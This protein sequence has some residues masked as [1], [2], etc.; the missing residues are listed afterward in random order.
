MR[1]N[2]ENS[3]NSKAKFR[4]GIR[5]RIALWFILGATALLTLGGY[6]V[7]VTGLS[8]IQGTLGQTYCQIAG[9]VSDQFQV[10]L[11][12]RYTLIRGIAT[13]VLTAAVLV[14]AADSYAKRDDAW[15]DAR[16]ARLQKEWLQ[17]TI[18]EKSA[19]LHPQ[20]S[21]RLSV[22]A[23]LERT[24]PHALNVYDNKGVLVAALNQ[25]E[26]RV[27]RGTDIY[28]NI[29][30][31]K[32]HFNYV[33]FNREPDTITVIL[34]VWSGT[35]IAGYVMGE[36]DFTVIM[37]GIGDTE[38]GRSGEAV[39]V[40][41]AGVPLMGTAQKYLFDAMKQTSTR[42]KANTFDDAAYWVTIPTPDDRG[43]WDRLACVA[44]ILHI[45]L[46]RETIDLPPWSVVVSQS[47]DESY[48]ALQS[49][50]KVLAYAGVAGILFI[51]LVGGIAATNLT[52]PLRQLRD[53]VRRFAAGN[54]NQRIALDSADEIG[55]LAQEFNR[56]ADRVVI[57]ENEL[58]AFAQ[59]VEDATDSIILT[60]IDGE[61]YY[62][63]PAFEE[64]TGYTQHEA[65]GKRPSI[66]RSP[67]TTRETH[68]AMWECIVAGR[69]WRGEIWNCRK[70]G[71]MYPV[72]L[73]ISPIHDDAGKIVSLLGIHR[74]ITLAREY[75]QELEREVDARTREIATTKGLAAMG[76]MASM[77]AHDLRNALSTVKMNLQILSRQREGGDDAGDEHFQIAL[78][79]VHYMEEFLSD[80]LIYARP[81]SLRTAPCDL[82]GLVKEVVAA[83]TLLADS[84]AVRIKLEEEEGLPA[85]LCDQLKV[86]AMLR[87]IVENAIQSITEGGDITISIDKSVY[88][89]K[90]GHSGDDGRMYVRLS[91]SDTGVGIPKDLLEEV[92][93]PFFTTRAK[94]T[95]LGL[96]I[97][98]RIIEQ[99]GGELSIVSKVGEGTTISFT[100]PAE[101]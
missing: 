41:Y 49:S 82:G 57:S 26:M 9:R 53:G 80:M 69:P 24:M 61:I 101:T 20:L 17:G 31:R 16:L 83:E 100:L 97:A 85:V 46:L 64:V 11:L 71:E 56:M 27:I 50:L 35:S 6:T 1:S 29:T 87:N 12:D 67:R 55:D 8:S 22:I 92:V 86:S 84:N 89:T 81:E 62:V 88:Q 98:K 79:Q 14:E 23:G 44:P 7:Y 66:L 94:G 4:L 37:D 99:H 78:G 47:P 96:A 32:D 5:G 72:D 15:T 91:V 10:R 70:N 39:V 30:K 48:A 54:R 58:N 76:R 21:S 51:S 33:E 95:G 90:N 40:D 65:I 34:P 45:N 77:V 38:F 28:N 60:D 36:F 42:A 74:D 73:T 25:P 19:S 2:L 59:A 68:A 52:R 13:D 63:N 93:E 75:Q 43:V 3:E 18:G